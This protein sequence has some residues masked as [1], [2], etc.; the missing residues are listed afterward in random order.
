PA[1]PGEPS[2]AIPL[3]DPLYPYARFLSRE[4]KNSNEL[5]ARFNII[6]QN[7]GVLRWYPSTFP[8]GRFIL[9]YYID[10]R[11]DSIYT[12][13][14]G[15]RLVVEYSQPPLDIFTIRLKRGWNLIS[16]PVFPVDY[17][18]ARVFPTAIGGLYRFDA[19]TRRYMIIE[20]PEAGEGFFILSRVDT[21]YSIVGVSVV[22]VRKRIFPGWNMFGAPNAPA[23]LPM[24]YIRTEPENAIYPNT[25][26]ELAPS[27]GYE[28]STS[29][30]PGKG[31]WVLSR[32]DAL[33]VIE[34]PR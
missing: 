3:S 34:R 15:E 6:T 23:P 27:G 22:S 24:D 5:P 13:A 19:A 14:D 11:T 33:L 30:S 1:T 28:L 18:L 29:I 8:L 2:C 25:I 16:L 21:T 20:E 4:F 17:S 31:Y 26:F 12:F 7:N 10:M 9:N 32:T